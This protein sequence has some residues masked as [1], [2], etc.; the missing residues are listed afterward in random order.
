[1]KQVL[2]TAI[3]FAFNMPL[4]A[5][6]KELPR[7]EC[8]VHRS[9]EVS[10]RAPDSRDG[11]EVSIGTG[12]CYSATLTIV[13]RSEF[14][15]I[16]YSY[17]EQFKQHTA[18]A[19]GDPELSKRAEEFVI[20]TMAHAMSTTAQLPPYAEPSAY[21]EEHYGT[22]KVSREEYERWRKASWPMLYHQTYYEGGRYA[23]Y[24]IGVKRSKVIVEE[25]L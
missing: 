3:F 18:L 13:V 12:P 4:S 16:L 15:E 20:Q 14:G 24:D 19:S 23:V 9:S 1:M 22:I 10:F 7:A 8:H 11:L 21:Y 6:S 17:V 2:V 25:G 5:P